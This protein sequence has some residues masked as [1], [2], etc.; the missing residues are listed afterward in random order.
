MVYLG[1]FPDVPTPTPA[2]NYAAQYQFLFACNFDGCK[3]GV[4]E[5]LYLM[6]LNQNFGSVKC[7]ALLA[8]SSWKAQL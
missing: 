6:L 7:K 8:F 3:L 2:K 1:P 4:F 5:G